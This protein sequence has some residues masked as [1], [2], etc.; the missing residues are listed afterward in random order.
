MRLLARLSMTSNSISGGVRTT[1]RA[2]IAAVVL[3]SGA[4]VLGVAS[5]AAAAPPQK[6]AVIV[7]LKPG[8]D[9]DAEARR[10]SN[11]G[12]SIRHTYRDVFPG[13]AGEFPPQ[14]LTGLRNNPRVELI[15]NDAV[16]TASATD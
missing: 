15:E 13:F 7:Q 8:A 14:A 4:A 5:P 9:P 10:A 6:T 3:M 2:A 11:N 12:A 16:A 1:G